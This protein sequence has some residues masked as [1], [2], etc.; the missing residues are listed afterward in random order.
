MIRRKPHLIVIV[1]PT[2]SGKSALAVRLAKKFSGEIVSAD[3]RQIYRGL[4]IGTGKISRREMMGVPHHLLGVADPA[5][6]F[7]IVEFKQLAEKA[8]HEISARGKIPI[9]TGGTMFWIDAVAY[10]LKLPA[11]PPDRALRKRLAVKN[12]SQLFAILSRLDPKRAKTIERENPRRLIRAIEIARALGH[13]PKVKKQM[14][15]RLLWLGIYLPPQALKQRI[16]KR[17]V[18]RLRQGMISEARRLH[19]SGL[20]WKRLYELGLEYRFLAD[21]LRQKTTRKD[22]ITKLES[23]IWRYG[24]RQ[25][26]WWRRNKDI[27]WVTRPSDAERHVK[28]FIKSTK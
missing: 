21:C 19:S 15:Y 8:I 14:P 24:I 3:S 9:L 5:R 17:L 4:D 7:N 11:V 25:A 26:S 2:A 10:G 16:Q 20:S 12:P 6:Q 1:G 13:T 28:Q 27:Q 18:K 22:M 23:A